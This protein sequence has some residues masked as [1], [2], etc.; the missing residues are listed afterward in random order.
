MNAIV[1]TL[2]DGRFD[3][4]NATGDSLL[5]ALGGPFRVKEAAESAQRMLSAFDAVDSQIKAINGTLREQTG[6]EKPDQTGPDLEVV[7][8]VELLNSHGFE[9]FSSCSGQEGHT[10]TYPMVRCRPC[11]AED[12]F[13]SLVGLGYSGFYVKEYRSAHK[14][15]AV[16]FIE[17]EFWSLDCLNRENQR[18]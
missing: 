18:A 6:G 1:T 15:S 13:N 11:N 17:V 10:W 2:P 4:Q 12:L 14:G 8:V 3:V 16:D 5:E 7:E 9:T